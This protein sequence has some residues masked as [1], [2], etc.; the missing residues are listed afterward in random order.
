M[1]TSDINII[2]DIQNELDEYL[3]KLTR[4]KSVIIYKKILEI[5]NLLDDIKKIIITDKIYSI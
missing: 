5:H 4:L 2:N 3:L 1:E